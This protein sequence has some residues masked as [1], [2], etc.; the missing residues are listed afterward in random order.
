MVLA[1]RVGEQVD[2]VAD[3]ARGPPGFEDGDLGGLAERFRQPGDA[4]LLPVQ[5]GRVAVGERPK[6]G[7]Q[8]L[9]R[10]DGEGVH[11]QLD[12]GEVG[13]LAVRGDGGGHVVGGQP[14]RA[15]PLGAPLPLRHVR[16]HGDVAARG[17]PALAP[18][19]QP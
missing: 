7:L 19:E 3:A 14:G 12:L 2:A 18:V 16:V 6:P 5:P 17:V 1:L 15:Q 9:G 8:L 4:G 13:A 10:G 11:G